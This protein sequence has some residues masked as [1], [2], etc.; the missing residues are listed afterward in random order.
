[1]AVMVVARGKMMVAGVFM[2]RGRGVKKRG[3]KSE[4]G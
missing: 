1:M 3:Q 2:W 4:S